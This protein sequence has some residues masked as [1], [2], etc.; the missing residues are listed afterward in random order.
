MT[1]VPN[2]FRNFPTAFSLAVVSSSD[3]SVR[4]GK[5]AAALELL[6]SIDQFTDELVGEDESLQFLWQTRKKT[7]VAKYTQCNE[8]GESDRKSSTKLVTR[9]EHLE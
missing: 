3:P 4:E 2:D 7:C 6:Y 1:A 8:N 5:P 9:S